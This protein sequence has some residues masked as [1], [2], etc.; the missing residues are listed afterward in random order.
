MDE[1][2]PPLNPCAEYQSPS[3]VADPSLAPGVVE[4]HGANGSRVRVEFDPTDPPPNDDAPDPEAEAERLANDPKTKSPHPWH[5]KPEPIADT[6][7]DKFASSD[8]FDTENHRSVVNLLP[9]KMKLRAL[10]IPPEL[11]DKT[12]SQLQKLCN[13]RWTGITSTLL[14]KLRIGFWLEFTRVQEGNLP[15]MK[16]NNIYDGLCS[17]KTFTDLEPLKLAYV[18]TP[19]TDYVIS[20]ETIL[21]KT[22]AMLESALDISPIQKVCRC[23]YFCQ[24]KTAQRKKAHKCACKTTK[25]CKCPPHVD[26]KLLGTLLEIH[27]TVEQRLKG[28]V[29]QRVKTENKT[30]NVN[31]DM[32]GRPAAHPE[33]TEEEIN[34][35]LEELRAKEKN[36]AL[37]LPMAQVQ[38]EILQ[39]TT[40]VLTPE[41]VE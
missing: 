8:L 39:S 36:R 9:P 26:A 24:C 29:V 1:K 22:T 27:K 5:K 21:H 15:V 12:P 18:M 38:P 25:G 23:H 41:V 7:D 2:R 13:Q 20:M 3:V 40:Q 4:L 10:A 17:A 6:P 35:K 16:L 31:M 33:L 28:A 30:L 37:A 19:P 34:K 32:T 11:R 14:D